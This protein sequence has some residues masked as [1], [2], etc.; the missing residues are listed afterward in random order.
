MATTT[1]TTA[2]TGSA[3]ALT[4]F[5]HLGLTVG[6]VAASEEW[7]TKVLGLVRVFV[8]PHGTGDGYAV[9][10]MRPGSGLFVGLDHH[11]DADRKG[12]ARY[13]P[14]STTWR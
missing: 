10:M 1:K 12:S 11:P 7:Y 4:G 13:A 2:T 5:H 3:P 8:E 14:G 6:D 9:V